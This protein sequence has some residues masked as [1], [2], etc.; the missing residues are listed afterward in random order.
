MIP[1]SSPPTSAQVR[2]DLQRVV[3]PVRE[4]RKADD[5]CQL[6]DLIFAKG[7]L[8]FLQSAF[9]NR[10]GAPRHAIRVKQNC[11]VF[12]V[13]RGTALEKGNRLD[14]LF[15]DAGPLRR[16]GMSARSIL[17]PVHHRCLQIS[18]LLVS[19]FDSPFGHDGAKKLE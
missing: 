16:S 6:H 17:A 15:R 14:L 2:L 12:L 19:G 3:E 18:Q 5:Q 8:E 1:G 4:V 11:L 9:A 10:S 7:S 13:K